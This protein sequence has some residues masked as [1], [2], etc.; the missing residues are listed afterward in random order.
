MESELF[1]DFAGM[2]GHIG[3]D[4]SQYKDLHTYVDRPNDYYKK[5][6]DEK[7]VL[8]YA[9]F[10][11]WDEWEGETVKEKLDYLHRLILQEIIDFCKRN[12]IDAQYVSLEADSLIDSINVGVWHPGTDSSLIFLDDN[13]EVIIEN[14]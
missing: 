14:L 8:N 7:R 12:K 5:L 11:E 10:Y 2:S 6:Y 13:Q 1:L 4:Y 3:N 9:Y